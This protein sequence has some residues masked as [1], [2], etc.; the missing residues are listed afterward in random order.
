MM[1]KYVQAL[2]AEHY[3]ILMKI[4]NSRVMEGIPCFSIFGS[5]NIV[6]MSVLLIALK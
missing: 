4:K 3:T 2:F 1:I 5:L 6:K